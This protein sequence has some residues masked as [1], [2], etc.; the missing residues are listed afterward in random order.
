MRTNEY[1][2][3]NCPRCG[4]SVTSD[5]EYCQT[6][7]YNLESYSPPAKSW[8]YVEE[9]DEDETFCI[10]VDV[11]QS[12]YFTLAH[13]KTDTTPKHLLNLPTFQENR[14]MTYSPNDYY[15]FKTEK[16]PYLSE[17]RRINLKLGNYESIDINGFK[18]L[19]DRTDFS[20]EDI[21]ELKTYNFY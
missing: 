14:F 19:F 12:F 6:C 20:Q 11:Q 7:G 2:I 9:A 16:Y 10:V 17:G 18:I 13:L 1:Q 15:I 8:G 21:E 5:D 3:F 4:Q